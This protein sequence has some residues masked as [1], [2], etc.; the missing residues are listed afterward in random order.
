MVV[1]FLGQDNGRVK[2]PDFPFKTF[3]II[4]TFQL[5]TGGVTQLL[6]ALVTQEFGDSNLMPETHVK[7]KGPN[8]GH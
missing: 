6:K 1:A 7:T 2:S 4:L 5:G 8:P 3:C